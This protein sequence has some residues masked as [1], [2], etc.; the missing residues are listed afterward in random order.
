MTSFQ[1]DLGTV[2]ADIETLQS[3]S[4]ALSTKLE[5]RKVVEKL[6]GPAIEDIT[7]APSVVRLISDGSIEPSW[8]KALK[9]LERRSKA[10]HSNAEGSEKT[11]AISDVKPLIDN[12]TSKVGIATA[13]STW[14]LA[15]LVTQGNRADT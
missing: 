5:N 3:R 7:L 14:T 15:N 8:I 11:A 1:K 10:I 12:L 2:S 6:L 4:S 13:H 9:E